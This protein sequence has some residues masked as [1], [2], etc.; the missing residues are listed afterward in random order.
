LRDWT[1]ARWAMLRDHIDV[2]GIEISSAEAERGVAHDDARV[3]CRRRRFHAGRYHL[4]LRGHLIRTPGL[5]S[6]K[7]WNSW[8][9]RNQRAFDLSKFCSMPTLVRS[10]AGYR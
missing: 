8:R 1:E 3:D 6:G 9:R 10:L 5:R 7:G 4:D 2:A